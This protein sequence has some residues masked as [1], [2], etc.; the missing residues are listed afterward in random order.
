ML[1]KDE[2]IIV[3]GMSGSGKT[4]ALKLLED[5]GYNC[6][7]NLPVELLSTFFDLLSR[8]AEE[9][10]KT[11][12]GIDI[13]SGE[14]LA[15]LKSVLDEIKEKGIAYKIL[16]LD[17]DD[18]A[19]IK[20]YKETRRLHPLAYGKRIEEGIKIER[21]ALAFLRERADFILDTSSLLSKELKAELTNIFGYGKEYSRLF[22]SILSFGFMYGIPK[23]VDLVFDVRFLPNP[24]Y[25]L[26]LRMKTGEDKE[27]RDYVFS[28]KNADIFLNKLEDMIR[29]LIPNYINEGKT[30]LIIGIGCTGGQH[31]SVAVACELFDRLG[32]PEKISIKLE[33]RDTQKNKHRI[34]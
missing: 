28:D 3:S 12:L 18:E 27:V 8:S 20:R 17:A 1:G 24:Y 29:F 32:S 19:L 23:D 9:V 22:V 5:M 2:I 4:V 16:F 25:D 21:K 33:H 26:D 6:I 34:A 14:G 11:A 10:K 7:D 30:Q 31:R 15:K 13:R